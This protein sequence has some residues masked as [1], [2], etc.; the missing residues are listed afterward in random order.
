M[1]QFFKRKPRNEAITTVQVEENVV[2][3]IRPNLPYG[4]LLRDAHINNG[5]LTLYFDGYI[6]LVPSEGPV[7]SEDATT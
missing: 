2:T 6:V 1:M 7:R 3:V 4:R 5:T